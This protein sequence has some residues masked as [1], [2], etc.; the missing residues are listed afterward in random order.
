MTRAMTQRR[1]VVLLFALAALQLAVFLSAMLAATG[2]QVAAPLDEAYVGFQHAARLLA[3]RP[4]EFSPGDGPAGA[5]TSLLWPPLLA[6]GMLA[7]FRG[8]RAPIFA[9][10]F[11]AGLLGLCAWHTWRWTTRLRDARAGLIAALCVLG[12][13]PLLWGAFSGMEVALFAC[14]LAATLDHTVRDPGPRARWLPI[15]WALALA[16][17][18][19]EGALCAGVL[20]LVQAAR[21]ARASK[22]RS[23]LAWSAP[24]AGSAVLPV[25]HFVFTPGAAREPTARGPEALLDTIFEG[26]GRGFHGAAALWVLLLFLIGLFWAAARDRE[27]REWGPGAV[28][29]LWLVPVLALYAFVSPEAPRH[30]RHLQPFLALFLPAAS[31]GAVAADGLI[32]RVRGRWAPFVSASLAALLFL[33]TAGWSRTF[34]DDARAIAYRQI[35]LAHF[36]REHVPEGGLVAASEVGAIAYLSGRRTLDLTGAL[37]PSLRAHALAGEGSLVEHLSRLDHPPDLFLVLAGRY[38]SMAAAGVFREVARVDRPDVMIA[39]VPDTAALSPLP[40]PEPDPL[41]ELD[42]S[43]LQSERSHAYAPGAAGANIAVRA[44]RGEQAS[45]EGARR[46]SGEERFSLR[47]RAGAALR[48]VARL[49]GPARAASLTVEVNGKPAGEW[50]LP[51]LNENAM[52]HTAFSLAATADALTIAL[53]PS[54]GAAAERTVG[55]Y[56]LYPAP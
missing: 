28:L 51:D 18:R 37:A 41:D 47:G 13:G 8:E 56:Y 17:S 23:L 54:S 9:M 43:D 22:W 27:E 29:L 20:A 3:L 19:P 6:L 10:L 45:I 53:K 33:Q 39:G 32:E 1:V 46:I 36:A 31:L 2:G 25:L 40:P 5:W 11:S 48:L 50:E 52:A 16:A 24:L 14:A 35:P 15:L 55:H 4:F 30:G 7:G 44:E 26:F 21:N 38:P 49:Y 34:A 42:V 12:S